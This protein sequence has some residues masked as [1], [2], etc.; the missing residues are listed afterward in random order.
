[1]TDRPCVPSCA[2]YVARILQWYVQLPETPRRCRRQD[3]LRAAELYRRGVDLETVECALLLGSLRRLGRS[4]D[5][6]PL[7]PIRSLAY[8]L[9]V[10]EELVEN[11]V[12]PS[13]RDYL[14]HKMRLH[15]RRPRDET[16]ACRQ[17]FIYCIYVFARS[18]TPIPPAPL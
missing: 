17:R 14:R 9:P 5:C 1:M 4:S 18:P 7:G 2:Q 11:P 3:L 8:F 10:V 12:D 13:Y 15:A 16:A 6:P